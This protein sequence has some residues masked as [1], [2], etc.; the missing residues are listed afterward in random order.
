MNC[1]ITLFGV[2]TISGVLQDPQFTN[3]PRDLDCVEL[4]T[5]AQ[6]L[7]QAA[8]REGLQAAAFDIQQD[9]A[10]RDITTCTG[11]TEALRLVMRLK[12]GGLLAMAPDCSSFVFAPTSQSGRKRGQFEGDAS[13]EFVCKG[14]LQATI[15]AFFLHVAVARGVEA[16]LENP[17][18]SMMFSYLAGTLTTLFWMVKAFCDRCRYITAEQRATQ[19]YKKHYKFMAT[20]LWI[21]TAMQLCTCKGRHTTL[22][23]TGPNGEVNGKPA[24]MKL[25][26]LY[27]DALGAALVRAWLGRTLP[28]ACQPDVAE[29]RTPR[30]KR[31]AG[32][33]ESP[34]SMGPAAKPSTKRLARSAPMQLADQLEF[35]WAEEQCNPPVEALELPWAGLDEEFNIFA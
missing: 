11:F 10:T 16:F 27:P 19:N 15:A 23:D 33:W 17:S 35:P 7:V 12:P 6:T 14:N 18:G 29:E 3:L 31:R 5:E 26:G 34:W 20:G 22:M 28:P 4:W 2:F 24:D 30:S 21:H 32:D 25:S 9:P 13:R 1:V 8:R